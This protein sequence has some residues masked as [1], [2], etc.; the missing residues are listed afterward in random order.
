MPESLWPEFK[1]LAV[2]EIK[3]LKI[4]AP[5]VDPAHFIGPVISK[6]SFDKIIGLIEQAK[7][8]GG[9]ILVGGS[10]D[11][12]KGFF[13]EPTLIVSKSPTSIT[14]TEEIFGP[15]VTAYVYPDNDFEKICDLIDSTS[16]YALT[17][18]IF[19]QD[20][21]ALIKAGEKLRNAAGNCYYNS[22][23]TGK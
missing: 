21:A 16:V 8:E 19:A 2:E 23:C 14:M 3:K 22:K 12:S 5:E 10:G 4:G 17:G 18:A 7:Q 9:E 20:R 1:A 6:A 11:A 13:V 15:V